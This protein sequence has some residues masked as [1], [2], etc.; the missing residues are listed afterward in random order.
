M[1]IYMTGVSD[2]FL[3]GI[4]HITQREPCIVTQPPLYT[5][6]FCRSLMTTTLALVNGTG[7]LLP[8]QTTYQAL[9]PFILHYLNA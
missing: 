3:V 9:C 4:H 7:P 2:S 6:I 5:R 8:R 1:G